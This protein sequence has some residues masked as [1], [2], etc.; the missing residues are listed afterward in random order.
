MKTFSVA[1]L[2][3]GRTHNT[4]S[5]DQEQGSYLYNK[6]L[7]INPSKILEIGAYKGYSAAY[8]LEALKDLGKGGWLHTVDNILKNI[9]DIEGLLEKV[10]YTRY[11]VFLADSKDFDPLD[12]MFGVVFIDGDHNYDYVYHDCMKYWKYVEEK[13]IMIMHDTFM[14]EV[15][16]AVKVFMHDVEEI[17][18]GEWVNEN[19]FHNG[20]CIIRRV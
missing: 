13:G 11:K 10:G 9:P 8:M 15:N 12:N 4:W 19:E 17:L 2:N 7:E 18:I 5:M 6:V 1:E 20:L 3:R 14:V 16:K